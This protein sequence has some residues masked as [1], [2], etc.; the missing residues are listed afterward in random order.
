V[1]FSALVVI[2]FAVVF[3]FFSSIW[4]LSKE[5]IGSYSGQ[6][7]KRG[8]EHV[9]SSIVR[10]NTAQEFSISIRASN[11]EQGKEGSSKQHW[12]STSRTFCENERR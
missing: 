9:Y 12:A 4:L 5:N 1:V 2:F 8:E 10:L 6:P 3:L 11:F 7:Q